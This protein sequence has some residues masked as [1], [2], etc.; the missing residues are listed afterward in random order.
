MKWENNLTGVLYDDVSEAEA[1]LLESF[2]IWDY[3]EYG[4]LNDDET[5]QKMLNELKRL[6]S[7]LW[8]I[9]FQKAFDNYCEEYLSEYEEEKDYEDD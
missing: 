3:I 9:L 1:S 6:D 8:E 5:I 2:D 7:P 4:H